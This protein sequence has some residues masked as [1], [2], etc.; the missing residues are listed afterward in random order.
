[1]QQ[2]DGRPPQC[3]PAARGDKGAG[4]HL[5]SGEASASGTLYPRHVTAAPN[6]Y[7]AQVSLR[8]AGQT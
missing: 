6:R 3:W 2:A 5:T 1:M 7:G 8:R 4:S